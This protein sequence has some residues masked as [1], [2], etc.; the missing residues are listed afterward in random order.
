MQHF[1]AS[2]T[3]VSSKASCFCFPVPN[4]RKNIQHGPQ[5]HSLSRLL[6]WSRSL[7]RGRQLQRKLRSLS[8]SSPSGL[9]VPGKE[10]SP[11]KRSCQKCAAR[12]ANSRPDGQLRSA[13][14]WRRLCVGPPG[15]PLAQ[16]PGGVSEPRREASARRPQ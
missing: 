16:L 1:R 7:N 15:C 6:G 12:H 3:K 5:E 8:G 13:G 11:Q 10:N 4:Q 14:A 9:L 2:P